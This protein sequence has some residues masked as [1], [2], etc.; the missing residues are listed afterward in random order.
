MPRGKGY[1]SAAQQRFMHAVHPEIA[2]RWDRET[3]RSGGFKR[4]PAKKG[5][6]SARSTRAKTAASRRRRK[7]G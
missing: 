3:K 5:K 7:K 6:Q 2:K 4:L 1:A